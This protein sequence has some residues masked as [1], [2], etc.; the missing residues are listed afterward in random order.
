MKRKILIWIV[1]TFWGMSFLMIFGL[2]GG[3]ESGFLNTVEFLLFE[4]ITMSVFITSS[5]IMRLKGV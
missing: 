1:E 4:V 3:F 5:L 2:A